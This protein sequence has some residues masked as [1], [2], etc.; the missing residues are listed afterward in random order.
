[1]N[2]HTIIKSNVKNIQDAQI[3][4]MA[5][6]H[7]SYYRKINSEIINAIYKDGDIILV[8]HPD[9]DLKHISRYYLKDKH[10]LSWDTFENRITDD[11]E[12]FVNIASKLLQKIKELKKNENIVENL[13]FINIYL[14]NPELHYDIPVIVASTIQKLK[15]DLIICMMKNCVIRNMGMVKKIQECLNYNRIFIIGGVGHFREVDMNDNEAN[16][17]QKRSLIPIYDELEKHSYIIIEPIDNSVTLK[18]GYLIPLLCILSPLLL[19]ISPL[20]LYRFITKKKKL[21][22]VYEKDRLFFKIACELDDL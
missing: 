10:I 2:Y 16:I 22:P 7:N 17:Y 21:S 20:L 15:H 12:N 19:L 1:M 8:E 6:Y 11:T 13:K 3:I 9:F 18:I 4:C 5:E 14:E